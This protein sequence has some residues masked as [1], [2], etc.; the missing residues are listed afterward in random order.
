[1]DY[2]RFELRAPSNQTIADIFKDRWA[3]DLSRICGVTHSGR[4]NLFADPRLE[5]AAA[6]LGTAGR[7]DDYKILELGPLEG[8]HSY[9]LER[10]GA[11]SVYAVEAN[12]EAFVKCLLVKEMLSLRTKYLCGD[13]SLYLEMSNEEFDLIFC[14]GILYHMH[15]PLELIKQICIHSS[16]C[17][18]WSHYY[19]AVAVGREGE[20][21]PRGAEKN[22]FRTIYYERDYPRMD[23][24][25]FLGGNR[26]RQAWMERDEIS[27]A[28][29][30]FGLTQATILHDQQDSPNGANFSCAYSRVIA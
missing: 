29:A 24:R 13:A 28:F 27:R 4:V 3:T 12:T 5:M 26:Q 25:L 22:G 20:R 11:R 8:A 6:T 30:H 15:D 10:L 9:Q 14:C 17:F 18:V 21:A 2:Q 7:F 1:M 16:R 19:D 23:E